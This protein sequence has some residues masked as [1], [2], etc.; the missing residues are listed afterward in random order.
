MRGRWQ[1]PVLT[2]QTYISRRLRRVNILL[3]KSHK[4]ANW[5]DEFEQSHIWES[6]WSSNEWCRSASFGKQNGG[7]HC[8]IDKALCAK[9]TNDSAMR[10]A[11]ANAIRVEL[12]ELIAIDRHSKRPSS[13]CC[14][15]W[16]A[17]PAWQPPPPGAGGGAPRQLF[18]V[19]PHIL[20]TPHRPHV[21]A[22][23]AASAARELGEALIDCTRYDEMD[24]VK[25]LVLVQGAD[26]NYADETQKTALHAASANGS[27][28]LVEFLLANGARQTPNEAG[29][30]PLHWAALNGHG[31]VAKLLIQQLRDRLFS[32][33]LPLE[34]QSECSNVASLF[35]TH[36]LVEFSP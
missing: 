6:C 25:D 19:K 2:G 22:M 21:V 33:V 26:V 29:N 8:F 18:S 15:P 9:R 30:S 36:T 14:V 11:P 7:V 17:H 4:F 13:K 20:H 5:E 1:P 31:D 27:L 23:A 12:V 35:F 34:L 10:P 16:E 3:L 28:P 24:D 32:C